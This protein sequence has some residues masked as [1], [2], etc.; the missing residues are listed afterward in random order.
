ML[1][2][3]HKVDESYNKYLKDL[4]AIICNNGKDKLM[5]EYRKYL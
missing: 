5:I 3:S 4:L 1:D 2:I